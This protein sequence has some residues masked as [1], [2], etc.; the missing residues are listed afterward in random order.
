MTLGSNLLEPRACADADPGCAN[1]VLR[2]RVERLARHFIL[3]RRI[4]LGGG[5]AGGRAG[6]GAGLAATW[7]RELR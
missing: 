3:T 2:P 4:G 7:A 5:A 6:R 1:Q